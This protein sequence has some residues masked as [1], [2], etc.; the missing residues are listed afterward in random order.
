MEGV[1]QMP[2]LRRHILPEIDDIY[3]DDLHTK[4]SIIILRVLNDS[5][6]YTPVL[7]GSVFWSSWYRLQVI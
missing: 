7:H 4:D 1:G 6:A 2:K 3:L 5:M